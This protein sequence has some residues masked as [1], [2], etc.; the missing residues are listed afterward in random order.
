MM[1]SSQ[2]SIAA[3]TEV[4][5]GGSVA[6]RGRIIQE[7]NGHQP[8]EN[9]YT[10]GF[11]L[12]YFTESSTSDSPSNVEEPSSCDSRSKSNLPCSIIHLIKSNPLDIQLNPSS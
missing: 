1:I 10:V 9:N 4:V 6:N 5:P 7:V 11:I 2:T 3:A 8:E 12:Y